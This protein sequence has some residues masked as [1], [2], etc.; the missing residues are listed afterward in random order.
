MAPP[1]NSLVH[2]LHLVVLSARL[3]RPP[4]VCPRCARTLTKSANAASEKLTNIITNSKA[5]G[6]GLLHA[7]LGVVVSPDNYLYVMDTG[8]HKVQ[9]FDA[10]SGRSFGRW[11]AKA[12]ATGS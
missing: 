1:N 8:H 10:K 12:Q 2:V 3:R 6:A 5:I 9:I 11:A 7:P 4:A